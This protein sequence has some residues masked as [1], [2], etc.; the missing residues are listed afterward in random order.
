MRPDFGAGGAGQY[1][2]RKVM[3]LC[4]Q[5][6]CTSVLDYG[7]GKGWLGAQMPRSVDLRLYDPAMPEFAE[8]PLPA[9]L[10]LC[11]D[12]MEHVEP[13]RVDA[14]I[15][16]LWTLTRKTIF[17]S[18]ALELAAKTL[19]DGRNAHI[20]LQGPLDWFKAFEPWFEFL[21]FTSDGSWFKFI[22]V[23]RRG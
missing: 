3:E 14:V 12:V 16:H 7:C 19:P 20:C 5:Y 6:Q 22:G 1:D 15:D 21:S 17:V 13:E 11:C 4:R 8:E 23:P 10:V 18:I 9:D 2:A